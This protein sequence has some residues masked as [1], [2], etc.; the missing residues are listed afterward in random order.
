MI[1]LP[2]KPLIFMDIDGCLNN[3]NTHPIIKC[4]TIEPLLAQRF[5]QILWR[6]NA[7]F[8][9][10]SAWRYMVLGGGMTLDGFRY[11]LQS[12]WIDANRIIGI[13]RK[14]VSSETM[15]RGAQITEW[16]SANA[17]RFNGKYLVIDDM[18]LGISAAKLNFLHIDGTVGLTAS[19][20]E[21][22]VSQL[23]K[24]L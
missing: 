3:H 20:V 1:S 18:D 12:H 19:D 7:N 4:N 21:K 9:V 13:T 24:T 5:N 17:S 2:K 8:V 16:L 6:T 23:D 22:A 14:D 11:M 15:D 10:S